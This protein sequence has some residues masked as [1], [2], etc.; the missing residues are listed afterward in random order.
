MPMKKN[1]R[2]SVPYKT[3][4]AIVGIVLLAIC[5]PLL[6]RALQHDR[7]MYIEKRAMSAKSEAHGTLF[8]T[9]F[10]CMEEGAPK[11]R[12]GRTTAE[13]RRQVHPRC[14]KRT[15][16]KAAQIKA[17]DTVLQEVLEAIAKVRES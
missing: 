3:L 16:E 5:I 14:I 1:A 11:R 12:R 8:A 6:I 2:E 10:G 17:S 7:D 4:R 9:Y 15:E 13:E